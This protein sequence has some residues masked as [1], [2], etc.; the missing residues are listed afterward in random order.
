MKITWLGQGGF[1]LR[2]EH[3]TFLL[4][5][6]FSNSVEKIDPTKYRRIPTAPEM[7][8]IRPDVLVFT[9]DHIDHFDPETAEYFLLNYENLTVLCPPSV[10]KKVRAVAS[11]HNYVQMRPGT[12]WTEKGIVLTAVS[13]FH[14]DP[15]A[16]GIIL[17]DGNKK[18]YITGDTLYN[19]AIFKE[20]PKKIHAL[21]LPV[22]GVGN[23]MNMEDAAA[24]S[25]R[26]GASHTVPMHYGTLDDIDISKF[27]APNQTILTAY[28]EVTL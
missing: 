21:F 4:D 27:Q 13:A 12:R 11:G 20:L 14:S 6:Y 1:L 15:D 2:T 8:R 22:N 16:I 10:W 28:E 5:P 7:A 25:R 24:F 18:Y 19:E 3:L 23:N 17:D 9:H 26:V